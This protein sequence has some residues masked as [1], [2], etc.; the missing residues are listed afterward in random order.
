[1]PQ[2][3]PSYAPL[4]QV[5]TPSAPPMAAPVVPVVYRKGSQGPV[6]AKLAIIMGLSVPLT[7][8]A[9]NQLGFKGLIFVWIGII[10]VAALALLPGRGTK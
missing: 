5:P 1:M 8:I 4:S 7:A 2:A 3:A 10:I 9:V 6:I